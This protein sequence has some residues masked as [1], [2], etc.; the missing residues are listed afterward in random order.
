MQISADKTLCICP[1]NH[2]KRMMDMT[3][4]VSKSLISISFALRPV[5]NQKYYL[6]K[7][8]SIVLD[9]DSS[10]DHCMHSHF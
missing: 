5:S 8:V 6:R 2:C 1:L 7:N 3:S 4:K 9:K 10:K